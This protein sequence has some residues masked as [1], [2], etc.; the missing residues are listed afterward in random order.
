VHQAVFALRCI[1]IPPPASGAIRRLRRI[2][3]TGL[4]PCAILG[5]KM[6]AEQDDQSYTATDIIGG[7]TEMAALP[8][9]PRRIRPSPVPAMH[10]RGRR[11]IWVGALA[12]VL[13]LAVTGGVWALVRTHH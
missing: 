9:E 3:M 4:A 7:T 10:R 12:I 13:L 5:A 2:C 8:S 11:A 1:A 6:K